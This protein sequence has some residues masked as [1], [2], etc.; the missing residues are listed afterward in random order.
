MMYANFIWRAE[1]LPFAETLCTPSE[2]LAFMAAVWQYGIYADEPFN[3]SDNAL[4]YFNRVVRPD[5]DRQH[6]KSKL[7]E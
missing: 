5:L 3:L 1:W 2:R 6:R 7:I 4:S